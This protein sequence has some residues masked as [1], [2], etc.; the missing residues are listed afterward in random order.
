MRAISC[1]SIRWGVATAGVAL[2]LCALPLAFDTINGNAA[3]AGEDG[4]SRLVA[5]KPPAP[6]GDGA[7]TYEEQEQ[8]VSDPGDGDE[9]P[10]VDQNVDSVND[11]DRIGDDSDVANVDASRNRDD[12]EPGEASLE[13]AF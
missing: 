3:R 4:N 12:A 8:P 9:T 10:P 7:I 2:L 1:S 5:G 6:A 11:G 13:Q